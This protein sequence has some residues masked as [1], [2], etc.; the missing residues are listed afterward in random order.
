MH[1]DNPRN[2]VQ[3]LA[4]MAFKDY[5]MRLQIGIDIMQG[6][7]VFSEIL[8]RSFAQHM[9]LPKKN[10]SLPSTTTSSIAFVMS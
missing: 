7:L 3:D 8:D 5:V 10:L 4:I 9:A 2:N 6:R 1:R